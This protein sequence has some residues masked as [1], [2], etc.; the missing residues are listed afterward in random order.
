MHSHRATSNNRALFFARRAFLCA[1][2]TNRFDENT[3]ARAR[4]R[5]AA[6]TKP[7][8]STTVATA[9]PK[10]T[11]PAHTKAA[12]AR[13]M[14]RLW[15]SAKAITP[16]DTPVI[17]AQGNVRAAPSLRKSSLPNPQNLR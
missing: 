17:A 14:S 9:A 1:L 12:A 5:A 10:A 7:P 16:T 15:V 4:L 8:R 2:Q 6:W 13:D 11:R 3:I